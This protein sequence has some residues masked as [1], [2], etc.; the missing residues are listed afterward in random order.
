MEDRENDIA[1]K[2]GQAL[3]T[4][5]G[6]D[7][8]QHPGAPKHFT[9]PLQIVQYISQNI[10]PKA[11]VW[12][13]NQ[14]LREAFSLEDVSIIKQDLNMFNQLKPILDKKD[15]GQYKSL[16]D[17]RHTLEA[18]K[19]SLGKKRSTL[20]L[21]QLI[22]P[23]VKRGEVSMIY[24]QGGFI[25]I[26]TKT[27]A[28]NC[29]LGAGTQWC[30]T[31]SDPSTFNEYARGG[32][33][34]IIFA[35]NGNKYQLQNNSKQFMNK[36]DQG[37]LKPNP[38]NKPDNTLDTYPNLVQ[39]IIDNIPNSS[40]ILQDYQDRKQHPR[41]YNSFWSDKQFMIRVQ[42]DIP[43]YDDLH[44]MGEV[45]LHLYNEKYESW[46]DDLG[47]YMMEELDKLAITDPNR[48]LLQIAIYEM[49]HHQ[50]YSGALW[51]VVLTSIYEPDEYSEVSS[52]LSEYI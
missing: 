20:N 52:E 24:N 18:N 14:Y 31:G 43:S 9:D 42:K 38:F 27:H 13:I 36:F 45:L 19:Q 34:Y 4:R 2:R 17:L 23:W 8:K 28:S 16:L 51:S 39:I 44:R 50:R 32:P 26:H 1:T 37:I 10:D 49:K 5:Y 41:L 21:E 46:D 48:M 35:P 12:L 3:M 30:T 7:L 6:V 22:D 33:I 29:A 47:G 15:L 40:W 25:I 11:I